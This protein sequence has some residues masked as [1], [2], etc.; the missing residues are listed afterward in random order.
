[1]CRGSQASASSSGC[2]GE[3][4]GLGVQVWLRLLYRRNGCANWASQKS[5]KWHPSL[6]RKSQVFL[7]V[8]HCFSLVPETTNFQLRFLQYRAQWNWGGAQLFI[9]L[10]TQ[11]FR[12]YGTTK[13]NTYLCFTVNS[14]CVRLLIGTSKRREVHRENNVCISTCAVSGV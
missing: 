14:V 7:Q 9:A 4:Q 10:S 6:T 12:L 1:M 8:L 11:H 3:R 13:Q 5:E 2:F